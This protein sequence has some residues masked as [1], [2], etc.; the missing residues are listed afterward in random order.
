[1]T[2]RTDVEGTVRAAIDAAVW[3]PSVHNTQPWWFGIS[4][5]GDG[6]ARISLH[7]DA[8]RR[9]DVADPDGREMLISCGAALFTLRLAVQAMGCEPQVHLLPAP[10]RPGLIADVVVD[11]A[12]GIEP[13]A[14]LAVERLYREVKERRTHRGPFKQAVIPTDVLTAL[15]EETHRENAELL[16]VSDARERRA[17]AAFT[18]VAEQ[19]QR[20]DSEYQAEAAR[21][22]PPPGTHRREGMVDRAYPAEDVETDPHFAARDFAQGRHWGVAEGSDTPGITGVVALIV[23]RGDERAD[24]LAAGQGMQRMLLHA[25]AEGL[26]AALHTQ[27]LEIP[28]LRR[29]IRVRLCHGAHP[30][31]LLRLGEADSALGTVR[32]T[33][34][35][36]TGEEA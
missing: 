36:L 35:E 2:V 33:P 10:D 9:L 19:L 13:G 16:L 26:S 11:P 17:L 30:Q 12:A 4:E 3:A 28:E 25:S 7:S 8:E 18:E 6:G 27:P 21:W 32:R 24:W 15:R 1:M 14:R 5:H 29:L 20:L 34:E 22:A 23:T 31:V